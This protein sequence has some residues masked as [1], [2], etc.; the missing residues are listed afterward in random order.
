MKKNKDLSL[1]FAHLVKISDELF[2]VNVCVQKNSVSGI[3]L[4]YNKGII[5]I[6]KNEF[7]VKIKYKDEKIPTNITLKNFLLDDHFLGK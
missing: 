3:L 7:H 1:G 2:V 6:I 4:E 5:I